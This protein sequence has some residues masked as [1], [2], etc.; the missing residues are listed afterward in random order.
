MTFEQI[1]LRRDTGI[2]K[3]VNIEHS[4]ALNES[5]ISFKQY[6]IEYGFMKFL[7]FICGEQNASYMIESESD[8]HCQADR[9]YVL[10]THVYRIKEKEIARRLTKKLNSCIFHK[11]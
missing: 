8:K 11:S 7:A 10:P 9:E 2:T 1:L 3:I 4:K 5:I 6:L